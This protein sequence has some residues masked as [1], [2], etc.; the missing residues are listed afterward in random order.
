M[1]YTFWSKLKKLSA[2]RYTTP[3]LLTRNCPKSPLFI[4]AYNE[5][6]VVDE[7]MQNCLALDY[8]ATNCKYSGSRTAATTTP[9]N[10][11]PTGPVPPSSTNPNDKEKPPPSTAE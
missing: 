7:K 11:F 6:D 8:P 10:G 3:C 1:C 9:T 4:A 5:E 2:N